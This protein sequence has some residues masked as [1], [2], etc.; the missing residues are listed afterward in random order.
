MYITY[1]CTSYIT[2]GFG[3]KKEKLGVK[4]QTFLLARETIKRAEL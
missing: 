1:V 3:R 4:L 2:V